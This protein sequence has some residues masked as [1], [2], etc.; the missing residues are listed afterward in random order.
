MLLPNGAQSLGRPSH[1][2][3][4]EGLSRWEMTCC[5]HMY[6]CFCNSWCQQDLEGLWTFPL[7]PEGEGLSARV[8]GEE[9]ALTTRCLYNSFWMGITGLASL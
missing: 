2:P 4:Q 3:G 6:I 1:P 9:D 8:A 5:C 7:P